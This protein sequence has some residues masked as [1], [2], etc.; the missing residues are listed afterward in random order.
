[1]RARRLKRIDEAYARLIKAGYKDQLFAPALMKYDM[2]SNP[3]V[4][5]KDGD[6]DGNNN[7][8]GSP[9]PSTNV[10]LDHG[11]DYSEN[12]PSISIT[13]MT[14]DGEDEDE[15]SHEK[16]DKEGSGEEPLII[17]SEEEEEEEPSKPARRKNS[18]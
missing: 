11:E 15:Q 14:K 6:G 12:Y 2:N 4:P 7:G 3:V 5:L 13:P 17:S 8:K 9:T 10:S 1:M 16:T 18:D